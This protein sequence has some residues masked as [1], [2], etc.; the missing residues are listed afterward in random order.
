MKRPDPSESAVDRRLARREQDIRDRVNEPENVEKVI[1]LG[2]L[3]GNY[4]HDP[5]PDLVMDQLAIITDLELM[6]LPEHRYGIAGALV[7]VAGLHPEMKGHW[8]AAAPKLLLAAERLTPSIEAEAVL[9]RDHIEFLWMLWMTTGD[10]LV[11]RRLFKEAHK[12]GQAGDCATAILALHVHLPE[13]DRELMNSMIEGRTVGRAP[14][15]VPAPQ[16]NQRKDVPQA[17]VTELNKYM[18]SIPGG[19]DRVILVGWTPAQGGTFIVITPDGKMWD[20][21]PKEW[22]GRPVA[23]LKA[24]AQQLAI[25]QQIQARRDDP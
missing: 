13:V 20:T 25:H 24:D 16:T 7:G 12:G 23:V 22:S 1:F 8:K 4:R 5:H 21:C 19:I 18:T 14:V 9:T 3:F 6:A 10:V 17:A 11:L 2:T 15:A